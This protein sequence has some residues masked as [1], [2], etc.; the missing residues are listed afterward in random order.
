MTVTS[1]AR[2]LFG[3]NNKEDKKDIHVYNE[4]YTVKTDDRDD[5]SWHVLSAAQTP[6]LS[7]LGMPFRGDVHPGDVAAVVVARSAAQSKEVGGDE[8]LWDVVIT[9]STAVEFDEEPDTYG[10]PDNPLMDLAILNVNQIKYQEPFEYDLD[11]KPVATGIGEPFNPRP[12]RDATRQVFT[13]TRN[14]AFSPPNLLGV[15]VLHPWGLFLSGHKKHLN[16]INDDEEFFDIEGRFCKMESIKSRPAS[17]IF[18]HPNGLAGS[19]AHGRRIRYRIVTYEVHVTE[20]R[21]RRR[22]S[23]GLLIDEYT[24]Q[25]V[26]LHAGT[27]EFPPNVSEPRRIT[28]ENALATDPWPLITTGI[29]DVVKF[30]RDEHEAIEYLEFRRY[31]KLGWREE[32]RL[33][34]NIVAVDIEI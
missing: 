8:G 14:E 10:E 18:K 1:V 4:L 9:Y 2:K 30:D 33:D 29:G 3:H 21:T 23:D 17:F 28:H 6:T 20:R 11:N 13:I 15:N 25:L 34:T 22:E 27:L 19:F 7:S 24:W 32:L 16:T 12:T 31:D 26:V 5:T